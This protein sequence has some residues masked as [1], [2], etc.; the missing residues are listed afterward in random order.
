MSTSEVQS[1]QPVKRSSMDTHYFHDG[2]PQNRHSRHSAGPAGLNAVLR[3]TEP[4]EAA[5]IVRLS[6]VSWLALLSEDYCSN[7]EVMLRGLVASQRSLSL[8][9][10]RD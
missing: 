8:A 4:R 10:V 1:A 9:I 3:T 2:E 5:D 7:Y 6:S